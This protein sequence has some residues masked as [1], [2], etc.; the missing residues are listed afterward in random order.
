MQTCTACRLPFPLIDYN[1]AAIGKQCV[2]CTR[3]RTRS[4]Q[5]CRS[6][7]KKV[8]VIQPDA[9]KIRYAKDKANPGSQ[10]PGFLYAARRRRYTVHLKRDHMEELMSSPC[11]YCGYFSKERCRVLTG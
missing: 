1:T 4:Q 7:R 3:C 11:Y 8:A 2:K 5:Y 9:R 10:I 6:H